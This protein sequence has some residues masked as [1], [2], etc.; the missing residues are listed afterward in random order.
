MDQIKTT[1][2]KVSHSKSTKN[3]FFNLVNI[4][5]KEVYFYSRT[6][7]AT[8]SLGQ[9]FRYT[10]QNINTAFKFN[11]VL[12]FIGSIYFNNVFL[13]NPLNEKT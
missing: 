8:I 1:T 7:F 3:I 12:P 10:L 6:Y 4:N 2:T 11:I 5:K 9:K 13:F